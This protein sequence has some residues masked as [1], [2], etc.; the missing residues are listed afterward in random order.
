MRVRLRPLLLIASPMLLL[1]A[2]AYIQWGTVGLPVLLPSPMLTPALAMEPSGF[3][4]WLRITHRAVS[5]VSRQPDSG[6]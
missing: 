6:I 2:A 1:V 4:A 5:T 3:P